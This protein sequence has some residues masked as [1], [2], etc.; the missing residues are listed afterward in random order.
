MIIID[1]LE[2]AQRF[3]QQTINTHFDVDLSTWLMILWSLANKWVYLEVYP[4]VTFN[5][6]PKQIVPTVIV[7]VH[8][9]LYVSVSDV[10]SSAV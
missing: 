1:Y 7:F 5:E 10:M 8:M 3:F 6:S 9:H 2:C 4:K